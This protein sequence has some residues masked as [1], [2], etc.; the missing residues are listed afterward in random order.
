MGNFSDQVWGVSADRRH[1]VLGVISDPDLR[2]RLL[3]AAPAPDD[4]A[5]VEL[6]AELRGI[7][8]S[9]QRLTDLAVDGTITK[10]EVQRKNIELDDRSRAVEGR[11]ADQCAVT[12]ARLPITVDELTVAWAE[13]EI[14]FQRQL[15]GL[16]IENITVAPATRMAPG[17]FDAD[18][19]HW[20]L[21]A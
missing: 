10:A 2:D 19:L 20:K 18:R 1:Y 12:I 5:R 11:L 9:R 17:R 15:T 14:G 8:L 16:L 21:R 13:G 3:A 6:L 4:T 7:D